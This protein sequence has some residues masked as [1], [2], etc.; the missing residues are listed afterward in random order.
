MAAPIEDPRGS[1]FPGPPP[2]R[3]DTA[4]ASSQS[5]LV[6]NTLTRHPLRVL[7]RGAWLV[8]EVNLVAVD[9]VLRVAFRR[10]GFVTQTRARWLQRGC[11]RV[12]RVLNVS[13][14]TSG[15]VPVRGLLVS[16]HLGYLDILVLSA[17]TPTAFVAKSE[18]KSWPV[19][20]WFARL[21]GTVFV[22]RE[23]RHD[24]ARSSEELRNALRDDGL[25][26]LFPEGTSSD[27]RT[28]LPFKSALL[29]PATEPGLSLAVACIHYRLDEGSVVDEVCYW[30]DM[31]LAPHLLNLLG[32]P[33]V[34]A[35]VSFSEFQQSRAD[36]KELARQL[37]AEVLRLQQAGHRT[38][39]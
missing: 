17:A 10:D 9:Y 28:V 39:G 14:H 34:S 33:G 27:G 15:P 25:V 22:Q 31:S 5:R 26:V 13:V 18:V 12:L 1:D 35:H 37:H 8:A 30:R 24:V 21:A 4:P 32:K 19:F 38:A 29:A 6:L 3:E 20:G 36:R 7:V 2:A 23:S 11:R 16:N